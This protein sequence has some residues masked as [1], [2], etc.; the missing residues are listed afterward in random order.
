[1]TTTT[2][3]GST[4][5][6]R[7]L[8]AQ[9][10]IEEPLCRIQI[11]DVCTLVSTQ[12]DHIIPVALRPDLDLVR[13]NLQGA[14]APCNRFKGQSGIPTESSGHAEALGFFGE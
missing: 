12:V 5:A 6:W 14:C 13:G 8:R 1:M 3:N 10:L 11:E 4:R 7:K 2:R 9:V